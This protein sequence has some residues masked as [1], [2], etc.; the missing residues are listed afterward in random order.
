MALQQGISLEKTRRCGKTLDVLIEG[1]G[2]LEVEGNRSIKG[3][4]KR[5]ISIG[6][7]YRMHPRSMDGYR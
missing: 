5:R 1:S 4:A 3:M 2:E 7:T 6:R